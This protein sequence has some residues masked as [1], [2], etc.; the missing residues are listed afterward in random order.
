[1]VNKLL[2]PARATAID[3]GTS[4]SEVFVSVANGKFLDQINRM[5]KVKSPSW[6]GEHQFVGSRTSNR[7]SDVRGLRQ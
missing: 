2:V 4:R 6:H 1:M 7:H 5:Q 3:V